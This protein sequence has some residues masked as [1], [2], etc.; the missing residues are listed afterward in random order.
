MNPAI[1]AILASVHFLL[2]TS[3]GAI[4]AGPDLNMQ[5]MGK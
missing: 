2:P 4:Y 1:F 5:L 3:L